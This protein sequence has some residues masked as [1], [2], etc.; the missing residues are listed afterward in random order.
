MGFLSTIIFFSLITLYPFALITGQEIPSRSLYQDF[1]KL[2]GFPKRNQPNNN[3]LRAVPFGGGWY[4]WGPWSGCSRSCGVG[5]QVHTRRCAYAPYYRR[6]LNARGSNQYSNHLQNYRPLP[7]LCKGASKKIRICNIQNCADGS[8]NSRA[9]LCN[10]LS[11]KQLY[12]QQQ[13]QYSWKPWDK[14]GL[15]CRLTCKAVG[16]AVFYQ[17]KEVVADGTECHITDRFTSS[18][19]AV[20]IQ[21][22]CLTVGCDLVAGSNRVVDSCGV[23]GGNNSTCQLIEERYRKQYDDIGYHDIV[24][25]P[26]GTRNIKIYELSTSQNYLAIKSV[27]GTYYFN[28]NLRQGLPDPSDTYDIGGVPFK[29]VRPFQSEQ[30]EVITSDGPTTIPLQLVIYH[31]TKNPGI[32]YRFV[33][34]KKQ[35]RKP[36]LKPKTTGVIRLTNDNAEAIRPNIQSFHSDVITINRDGVTSKIDVYPTE[37]AAKEQFKDRRNSESIKSVETNGNIFI[38]KDMGYGK[39][40]KSCAAGV[41]VSTVKCVLNKT[42]EV[43][44]ESSCKH[45]YRQKPRLKV[46]NRKACGP[47]YSAGSWSPC[48][49]SCGVGSRTRSVTCKQEFPG[50][51]ITTVSHRKCKHVDRPETHEKCKVQ[52]CAKWKF[53][54]EW[55]QCSV[56]CGS[57]KQYKNVACVAGDGTQIPEKFCP[58]SRRPQT[59]RTCHAGPCITRWFTAE[60]DKCTKMDCNEVGFQKRNVFCVNTANRVSGCRKNYKPDS[61]RN[62]TADYDVTSRTCEVKYEWFSSPWSKCSVDCG[63]GYQQRIVSCMKVFSNGTVELVTQDRCNPD[64]KPTTSQNCHIANCDAKWYFTK[65]S[66]CSKSCGEGRHFRLVQC[67]DN[68]GRISEKC[69]DRLKPAT[70]EACTVSS[71]ELVSN[72]SCVDTAKKCNLILKSRFCSYPVYYQER[73]C[74]TCSQ[75]KVRKYKLKRLSKRSQQRKSTKR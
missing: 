62:C 21:G 51:F 9:S 42:H 69:E 14:G 52:D 74:K 68:E 63:K 33:K 18:N 11:N 32:H 66:T 73:C 12:L 49:K 15:P 39:C 71:C 23:C 46:C 3:Q 17:A 34:P 57:G 13:T 37:K 2:Q 60:W 50:N 1:S 53:I 28:G 29:Y 54:T 30:G 38:W 40:S 25:I 27:E 65:W 20:C 48:S 5:V 59:I 36:I 64:N 61:T 45:L 58:L 16:Q 35:P 44:A 8:N 47:Y 24:T 56:A 67:L 10:S 4:S 43:V 26:S 75:A 19:K 41:Q 55:S 31:Q 7:P 70:Q 6:R 72:S 22:H